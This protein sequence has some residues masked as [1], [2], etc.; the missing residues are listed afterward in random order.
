M[1]NILKKYFILLLGISGC[2][3]SS[4]TSSSILTYEEDLTVFRP[5]VIMNEQVVTAQE[6]EVIVP[7]VA[8]WDITYRLDSLLDSIAV[9]NQKQKF[10]QGYTI[11]VYTGSSRTTANEIR[12]EVFNILHGTLP[13]VTYDL[14]NYKVKVGKFYHRLEAQRDFAAIKKRFRNAI[15]V[16]QQFTID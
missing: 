15:L 3:T 6:P 10:I 8:E 7:E 12:G 4:N 9:N 1:R 5:P 14:P 11:Q 13:K 2:A 16:P